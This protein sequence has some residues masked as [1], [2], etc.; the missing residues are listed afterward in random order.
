MI[1]HMMMIQQQ[2][3]NS[4]DGSGSGNMAP[5]ITPSMP[6]SINKDSTNVIQSE[7]FTT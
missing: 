1:R 5:S 2:I 4:E 6:S 3:L 7:Q